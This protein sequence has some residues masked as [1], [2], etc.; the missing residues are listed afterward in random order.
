MRAHKLPNYLRTYRKR[1]G[2]SQDEMA[3]LLR[4]HDGPKVCHYER[5]RLTPSLETALSYEVIFKT[6][7]KELV[8]GMYRKV[9]RSVAARA[10]V[11]RYKLSRAKPSPAVARKLA[12]LKAITSHS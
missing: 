10:A 11:L 8:R 5:Y 6:P 9:E 12:A 7:V 1:L 2:F 4:L 3:F